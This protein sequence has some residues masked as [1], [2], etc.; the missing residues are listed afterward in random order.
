[1]LRFVAF[2]G[3]DA[4]LL[5]TVTLLSASQGDILCKG[6]IMWLMSV[7]FLWFHFEVKVKVPLTSQLYCTVPHGHQ[8]RAPAWAVPVTARTL[9]YTQDVSTVKRNEMISQASGFVV[10]EPMKYGPGLLSV[11]PANLWTSCGSCSFEDFWHAFEHFQQ[12]S[13]CKVVGLCLYLILSIANS[14]SI[15]K[16]LIK[17]SHHQCKCVQ[18]LKKGKFIC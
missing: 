4:M 9:E 15:Y 11:V 18:E 2:E 8:V 3:W 14:L 6:S 1:M 12:L 13:W 10:C 7:C 5:P 17:I 16:P